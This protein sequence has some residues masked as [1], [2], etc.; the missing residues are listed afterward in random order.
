MKTRMFIFA[1]LCAIAVAGCVYPLRPE[2]NTEYTFAGVGSRISVSQE[3]ELVFRS[4]RAYGIEVDGEVIKDVSITHGYFHMAVRPDQNI[5]ITGSPMNQK[6]YVTSENTG[7]MTVTSLGWA[8]VVSSYIFPGSLVLII[9]AVLFVLPV[10]AE[11]AWLNLWLAWRFKKANA[12][13]YDNEGESYY[14]TAV[15][16]EA[17]KDFEIITLP[18]VMWTATFMSMLVYAGFVFVLRIIFTGSI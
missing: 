9:F 8:H 1:V 6:V 14:G 11:G 4:D 18:V 15:F 10:K 7:L 16:Q 3:T 13:K 12:E 2:K 17:K 5:V